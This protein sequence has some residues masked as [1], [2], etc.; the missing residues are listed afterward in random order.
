MQQLIELHRFIQL[1][2]GNVII[3]V[4]CVV[5]WMRDDLCYFP[6]NLLQM[7]HLAIVLQQTDRDSL[8]AEPIDAVRGSQ[9][10]LIVE[11]RA[12]TI[13]ASTIE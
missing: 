11:Q 12:G 9:Q 8:L 1:D 10:E 6:I 4:A 7:R 2:D 3:V 5:L 13:E